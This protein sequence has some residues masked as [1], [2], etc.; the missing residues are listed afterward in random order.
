MK[1]GIKLG[2]SFGASA[3]IAGQKS[4]SIN[5]EPQ[6][7]GNST[8]G[9]FSVTSVVSKALNV[10]VGENIMFINNVS[11][12]EQAVM[13]RDANIIK[14]AEDNGYNIDTDAKQIAEDLT[15]WGI[16]KGYKKYDD[17]GN[18]IMVSLRYTKEEKEKFI[19]ENAAEIVAANR[20]LLIERNGGVDADD[21]TLAAL[22]SVDDIESP[23]V[24]DAEGSRTAT[25]GSATGV[26]CP[27][28]FTDTATWNIL[29]SDL[30]ENKT[31][32]NRVFKVELEEPVTVSI[33]NGNQTIDVIVYP[34]EYVEDKEVTV[35]GGE[36]AE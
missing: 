2:L 30:G 22:I 5:A 19:A 20:A 33:K 17:K 31:K 10:A 4:A 21:E 13:S 16:A 25:S 14:Y 24:H 3:V 34:I 36:K 28:S 15:F 6:L 12:I 29:K 1:N 32:K 35:R 27:L 11:Q 23:K 8:S 26:G 18:P 7:I 9:K